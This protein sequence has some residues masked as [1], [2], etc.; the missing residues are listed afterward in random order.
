ML[1]AVAMVVSSCSGGTAA[2]CAPDD[3]QRVVADW[4][5]TALQ[6]IRSE[7]P[8]PTIHARNLYHTSVAMWDAWAAWEPGAT[9]VFHDATGPAPADD[10]D[11]MA[12]RV[13]A[14]SA[15]ARD[16]LVD[17][18]GDDEKTATFDELL[19]D[20]CGGVTDGPGI[21]LGHEVATTVL[22]ATADDGWDAPGDYDGPRND[23]MPVDGRGT[24]LTDPQHWQPLEFDQM[25]T[26]NGIPLDQTVQTFVGANWGGVTT[27][28]LSTDDPALDLPEP[29]TI[30]DDATRDE[31]VDAMVDVLRASS[32][33]DP[34]DGVEVDT[35]P[36]SVGNAP[37][38]SA[39]G[40]GYDVNPATGQAYVPAP[41][42]RGDHLRIIAEYWADGPTSETPPG[43]WNSIA[44]AVSDALADED[45][46]VGGE[47]PV[48]DRLAWDV[49]LM[50]ALNGALHDAAVAAWGVKARFDS[51]R[52]VSAIRWMAGNGQSSDPSQ[53]SYSPLGLPLEDGFIE[54][55]TDISAENQHADLVAEEGPDVIGRIAVRA[56]APR[57]E[58]DEG[59]AVRWILGEDWLP[60][61][62]STFVTPAFAGYVSGHSTFSRSAAE[63]LTAFTG[64]EYFPSGLFLHTV[65][66]FD[67]AFE[68]G[69]DTDV[70]LQWATY[71][72]AAD[73]AGRSRIAGGIHPPFDDLAGRRLGARVGEVAW[74]R[75]RE[76]FGLTG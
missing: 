72:D 55:I 50:I 44:L 29:P 3:P 14:I 15:A 26:Q 52:P 4:I 68:S 64:D 6:T 13:G 28:A 69:P 37:L 19:D 23:P 18:Y 67:L 53:P 65:D 17:R 49:H 61:Q 51:I 73:E 11:L 35:S 1:L 30:L 9:A 5:E 41:V 62:L 38:G 43:H 39:D 32:R 56:W 59:P 34:A 22:E 60:Y 71:R 20:V 45:R 40:D 21:T 70:T 63:I 74:E 24:V 76:L 58:D 7:L 57:D 12:L 16:V 36:A 31:F 25:V 47:G 2:G 33:L 46:R 48:V 54:V 75:S 10:A 27:F 8:A 42:L 66:A